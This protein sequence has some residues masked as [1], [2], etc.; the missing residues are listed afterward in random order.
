MNRLA[1]VAPL[2]RVGGKMKHEGFSLWSKVLDGNEKA[3]EKMKKYNIQD[4]KLLESLYNKIKPFIKN[5]PH[6]GTEKHECGACGSKKTQ[7]RG[8]RRTKHFKIQRIQCTDCGSWS[9][10]ARTKV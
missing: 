6:L 10:G 2:L 1:F 4:V 9:E 7:S 3:R 8:Y 5:H